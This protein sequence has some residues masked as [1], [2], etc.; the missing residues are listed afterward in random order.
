MSF[1]PELEDVIES[2]T[3]EALARSYVARPA[4]VLSYDVEDQTV[5]VMP[6]FGDLKG[7]DTGVEHFPAARIDK[8]KVCFPR[9]G[10]HFLS[11]PIQ[12][13]DYVLLVCS[14]RALDAWQKKGG[15][16]IS[17]MDLRNHQITD[18][19]AIPGVYPDPENLT[20]ADLD[21][22]IVLGKQGG[23]LVRIKANGVIELGSTSG[24][25]QPAA[26]A[27]DVKAELDG[28]KADLDLF[29]AAYNAQVYVSDGSPVPV[30]LTYTPSEVGSDTVEIEE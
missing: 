5:S 25:K 22:D 27:D 4:R 30:V 17:L 13:N 6:V 10:D 20:E 8:V 7:T 24:T 11:F 2:A 28:I 16:N 18:A 3:R 29:V 9:A 26:L 23:S 1:Y 15:V 19:I 21:T 12:A 14:D